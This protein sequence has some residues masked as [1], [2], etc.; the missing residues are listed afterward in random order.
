M[1]TLGRIP[2]LCVPPCSAFL[3]QE[4]TK[5]A[6]LW[7]TTITMDSNRTSLDAFSAFI[8]IPLGT[9]EETVP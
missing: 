1:A 3:C 5:T 2:H 8:G 7:Q 9:N 6:T 4:T